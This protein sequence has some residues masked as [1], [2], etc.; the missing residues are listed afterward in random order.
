MY[1]KVKHIDLKVY[2]LRQLVQDKI[3][4]LYKVSSAAQVA[5]SL[6]KSTP[7]PVF[8]VHRAALLGDRM[9]VTV[10]SSGGDAVQTRDQA[11]ESRGHVPRGT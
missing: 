2:H 7:Y 6:T 1:N 10:T 11:R 9:V 5:D 4:E 8:R 3:L